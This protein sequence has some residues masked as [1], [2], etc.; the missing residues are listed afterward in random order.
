MVGVR[1]VPVLPFTAINYLAGLTSAGWWPYILGTALGI[2]PGTLSYVTLG[3]F[4]AK[5]GWQVQAAAVVLGL[6]TIAGLVVAVRK[7][8]R[9]R[10]GKNV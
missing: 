9:K 7:R 8:R 4:G 6:L 5:L 2:L 10:A 1:L 3:A